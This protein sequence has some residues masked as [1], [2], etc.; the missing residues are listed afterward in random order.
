MTRFADAH[1]HPTDM[2]SHY[3]DYEDAGIVFACSS[4]PDDWDA[5]ARIPDPRMTR[6]Y[7]VHPWRASE[8]DRNAERL[9]SFLERDGKAGVGEIGMDSSRDVPGQKEAFVAQLA[10]AEEYGRPVQVH[11]V[12]CEKD[13]LDILREMRPDVPVVMHAFS[14][15]SYSKPFAELGCYLSV[16]P[17]VLKRSDVRVRR[18]MDS[19]PADRLLLESDYPFS[20]E[21]FSGMRGFAERLSEACGIP[22]DALLGQSYDNARRIIG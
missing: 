18:L 22:A 7:G 14:S 6:F 20:P 1:C 17:R 3:S 11:D 2:T 8:W 9:R 15:E 16:N 4:V 19:I 10:L 21:V 12:G 13:I 5:L